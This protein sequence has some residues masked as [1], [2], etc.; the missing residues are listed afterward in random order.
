MQCEKERNVNWLVRF[1]AFARSELRAAIHSM[2]RV[3]S[4]VRG[5]DSREICSNTGKVVVVILL[6]PFAVVW[7]RRCGS[8]VHHRD[9]WRLNRPPPVSYIC[10]SLITTTMV[11][12]LIPGS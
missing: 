3:S 4:Y 9:G 8:K 1:T 6:L 10:W 11:K 2:Y 12:V 7:E 5:R